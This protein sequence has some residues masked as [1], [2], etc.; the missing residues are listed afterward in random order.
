MKILMQKNK[1]VITGIILF[2]LFPPGGLAQQETVVEEPAL[3]TPQETPVPT[4]APAQLRSNEPFVPTETIS[5]D[6][7]VP[8]PVDI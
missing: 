3:P 2:L 5:E 7:S 4:P 8:F 6:L 1:L